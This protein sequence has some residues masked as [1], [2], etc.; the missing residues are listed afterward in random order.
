[1]NSGAMTTWIYD[2]FGPKPD[3]PNLANL[4]LYGTPDAEK[5][6]VLVR[7]IRDLLQREQ[8]A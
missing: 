7:A 5:L 2:F 6:Q 3:G 8:L 1:M 4:A